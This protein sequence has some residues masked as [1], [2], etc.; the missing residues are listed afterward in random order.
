MD[1]IPYINRNVV[2]LLADPPQDG[3]HT[4][5]PLLKLIDF[6]QANQVVPGNPGD[7]TAEQEN[8]RGIGNV[9]IFY[10]RGAYSRP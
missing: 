5:A 10:H 2:V 8:I 4:F 9:R 3:E 1:K 6:G 7:E